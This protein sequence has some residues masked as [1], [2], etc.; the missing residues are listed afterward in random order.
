MIQKDKDLITKLMVGKNWVLY[1]EKQGLEPM[2]LDIITAIE[3]GRRPHKNTIITF[4][5]LYA[6]ERAEWDKLFLQLMSITSNIKKVGK[7]LNIKKL[8][9]YQ[10]TLNVN[11]RTI[12]YD[13]IN[14]IA[15]GYKEDCI[16]ILNKLLHISLSLADW[17]NIKYKYNLYYLYDESDAINLIDDDNEDLFDSVDKIIYPWMTTK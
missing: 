14:N 17:I 9:V 10:F 11:N 3:N 6:D 16:E 1:G 4:D 13:S 8:S 5:N 12:L 7:Q 2:S 15:T